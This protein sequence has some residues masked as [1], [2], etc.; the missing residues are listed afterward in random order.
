MSQKNQIAVSIPDA[1]LQ[2][3]AKLVTDLQKAVAPYVITLTP[4][5]RHSLLKMSDKSV[6][7]VVKN[8]EYTKTNPEFVPP[9]LSVTDMEADVNAIEQLRP[10]FKEI[11]QITDNLDDTLMLSGSE[12]FNA[13]LLYYNNVKQAIKG[14]VPG[15][16][17]IYEDL[18]KRYTGRTTTSSTPSSETT[19]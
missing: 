18:S 7:F 11:Q 13:A 16:K 12:A 9:F 6:A 4:E 5:N 3:I 2:N 14:N 8:L 1:E 19:K 15:A 10:L 17:T